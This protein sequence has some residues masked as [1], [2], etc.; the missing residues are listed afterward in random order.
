MIYLD[1]D[2]PHSRHSYVV[3]E[4]DS[5]ISHTYSTST[6]PL[7]LSA[8]SNPARPSQTDR[9]DP[10][11]R[12]VVWHNNGRE[13]CANYRFNTRQKDQMFCPRCGA[14]LGIDF[15][16]VKTPHQYGFSVRTIYGIDLDKLLF[17]Q[18]DGI[19]TVAP[20]GDLSGH[21]WDEEK[22]EMK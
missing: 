21:Y 3:T 4:I 8:I 12:D 10:D 19:N 17:Q 11:A 18:G 2:S 20:A 9:P 7:R 13:R 15:R 1:P 6:P 22:Q 14:S 16:E 5:F